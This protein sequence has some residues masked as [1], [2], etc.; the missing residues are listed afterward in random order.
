MQNN[1]IILWLFARMW[2]VGILPSGGTSISVTAEMDLCKDV[3][4]QG[5]YAKADCDNTGDL[6]SYEPDVWLYGH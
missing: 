5:V 6:R 4:I 3:G 2:E 1:C